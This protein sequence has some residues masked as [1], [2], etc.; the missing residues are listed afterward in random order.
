MSLTLTAKLLLFIYLL[1]AC[2]FGC[3]L[4]L[5]FLTSLVKFTLWNLGKT[6]EAE[7][8]LQTRGRCKTWSHGG[9]GGVVAVGGL[10][11]GRP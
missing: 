8:F 7:V 4:F 6:Y 2:L 5:H 3:S 10:F 11:Q 1:F 9:W